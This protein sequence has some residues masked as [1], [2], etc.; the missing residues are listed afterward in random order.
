MK[1]CY[2]CLSLAYSLSIMPSRSVQVVANAECLSCGWVILQCIYIYHL[3]FILFIC[4]RSP[5]CSHVVAAVSWWSAV[6]LEIHVSFRGLLFTSLGDNNTHTYMQTCIHK[7]DGWIVFFL[8]FLNFWGNSMLFS[9][10]TAPVYVPTTSARRFSS[11]HPCLCFC[12]WWR[13]F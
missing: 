3:F 12:L 5:R 2:I 7:Q 10:M 1:P 4:R 13:P 8:V 11:P 9:V 6:N